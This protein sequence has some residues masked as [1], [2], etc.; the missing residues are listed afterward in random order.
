ME[1]ISAKNASR[2]ELTDLNVSILEQ[3][4]LLMNLS[5]MIT[6]RNVKNQC[7]IIAN[8]FKQLYRLKEIA[9]LIQDI[10]LDR[11]LFYGEA[12]LENALRHMLKTSSERSPARKVGNGSTVHG[13]KECNLITVDDT[14]RFGSPELRI[15]AA[16]LTAGE[17]H[18][19]GMALVAE[20]EKIQA[21]LSESPTSCWFG[22]FISNLLDNANLPRK[23]KIEKY[24]CSTFTKQ[25]AHH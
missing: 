9:F 17:H 2:T 8:W 6:E 5:E 13:C 14:R 25:L 18:I 19:G 23:K 20:E 4:Q 3:A 22:P 11:T 21:L 15:L 24:A 1:F 7:E 12:S 16:P 10:R